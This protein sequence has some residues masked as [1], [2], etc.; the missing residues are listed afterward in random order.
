MKSF[1]KSKSFKILCVIVCALFLGMLVAALNGTGET[2]QT[3]VV[4]TVFSPLQKAAAA[5]S[6]KLDQAFGNAS[7]RK[8]YENKIKELEEEIGSLRENLADYENVKRQNARYAEVL[9]LKQDKPEYAFEECSVIARETADAF[10]AFT[11]GKGTL[12]G[13]KR[14]NP[15]VYGKYLVGIVAEVYP[16][17]AVVRTV[18]DQKFNAAAYEIVSTESGYVSGTLDLARDGLCRIS[19]L[20]SDTTV[21]EG[22]IICT[23]G[24]GGVFPADLLIG[25][26]TEVKSSESDIS[27]YGVIQPGVDIRSL[28]D[29]FVITS[30]E[31]G[32]GNE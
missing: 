22:S 14:G 13:I 17:Y 28:S 18:L 31:G 1:L 15:V 20:K 21:T 7:G 24:V 29:V 8:S 4:G 11:I 32:S 27:T 30:Y 16:D 2:A 5:V 26:V 6:D 9:E 10:Y 19:S 23:S 25:K 12:S 3:T